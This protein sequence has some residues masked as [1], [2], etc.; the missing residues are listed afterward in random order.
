MDHSDELEAVNLYDKTIHLND[1]AK[2]IIEDAYY[3]E[4][5]D[6]I[7]CIEQNTKPAYTFEKDALVLKTIDGI[8]V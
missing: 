7:R 2:Y 4:I 5:E 8:E 6:F 1:Y 3:D